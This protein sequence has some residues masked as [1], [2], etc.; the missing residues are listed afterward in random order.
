LTPAARTAPGRGAY[1]C[2][3]KD[4]LDK[5]LARRAFARAFRGP[6]SIDPATAQEFAVACDQRK[7]VR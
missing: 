4:C 3:E 7:A 1:V 6:V 5:A 2:P